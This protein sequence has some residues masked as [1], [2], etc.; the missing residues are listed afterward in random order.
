MSHVT[1]QTALQLKAAG[2]PQPKPAVGQV[3]YLGNNLKWVM[4]HDLDR[5]GHFNM[6]TIGSQFSAS[7]APGQQLEYM[8]FAPA[9]EDIL[10]QMPGVSI[11]YDDDGE[12]FICSISGVPGEMPGV[13]IQYDDDGEIFICSISGVPGESPLS[14]HSFLSEALATAYLKI[15]G[16]T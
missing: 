11:Q 2:F 1:A 16:T 3:W 6:S 9:A 15:H 14:K 12:I 10:Q 7:F 13:S 5:P 4:S 8:A